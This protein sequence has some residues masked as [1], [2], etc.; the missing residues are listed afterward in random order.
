MTGRRLVVAAK[1]PSRQIE[2]DYF[3]AVI[4]P[5]LDR[6]D[7]TILGELDEA[8]RDRLVAG[9]RAALVPSAWP[10]PFGL[11]VIEALACGTPVLARRAGAIP[12]ILRDGI[13]GFVGDDAQQLAFLDGRL[14]GLDRR[15]DPGGGA[16]AV[17]GRSDGGRLRG[18][19]P[20]DAG[21]L[22]RGSDYPPT[23]TT[24]RPRAEPAT[25]RVERAVELVERDLGDVGAELA[26]PQVG[27]QPIPE[28]AAAG[29]RHRHRVHAEQRHAA[30]DERE[31]RR[32]EL[33]AT[34]VARTRR[35]R[36]RAGA[37]AGRTAASPHRRRRPRPA[38]RSDSS[39]RP[40]AV[41]SSRDRIPDAPSERSRSASSGLPVAAQTS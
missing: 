23:R 35:P 32:L 20:A 7:V 38:H 8:E 29:D 18:A 33:R 3:D 19:L 25:M 41:T 30:Q 22:R 17:L 10:E 31:D 24:Q 26:R 13:D 4:R 28:L 36:A 1:I 12:E 6:A 27:R 2:V 15:G 39:G 9:S 5:L 37:S 40:S 34:G 16:G 21:P 14:D 11:V